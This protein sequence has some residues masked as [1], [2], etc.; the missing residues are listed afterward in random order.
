[1][2]K[3]LAI[4]S[5]TV[6]TFSVPVVVFADETI[7]AAAAPRPDH[8]QHIKIE[9]SAH[10]LELMQDVIT[11]SAVI[12]KKESL[13]FL[14]LEDLHKMS[15]TL[16][17]GVERLREDKYT[18]IAKLDALDEAVQAFHFSTE[19]Q[20]EVKTREWFTKLTGAFDAIANTD[21]AAEPEKK[22]FYEIIIKDH[23]FSPV[24]LVVPADQKV[25]LI[26]ENL[27]ETPEE[28]ESQDF[29]REKVIAGNSKATIFI[30]PLKAGTYNYFGEFNKDSAQG[31]I[32]AK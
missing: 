8:Y 13:E 18:D 5:V 32:I 30:G 16:E 19:N 31:V 25:K 17:S 29:N 11:K 7:E 23:K 9:S 3:L 24:Q 27:D 6:F 4:F 14:D 12:L 22:D 2:K 1:M 10:A 26:V 28:F 15:Y 21:Q 20:N